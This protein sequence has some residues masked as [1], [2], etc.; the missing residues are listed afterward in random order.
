MQAW[1][2]DAIGTKWVIDVADNI[3]ERGEKNLQKEIVTTIT[4]FDTYYSRFIPDSFVCSL[5]NKKGIIEVEEDFVALLWA[6]LPLYH[7]TQGKFTPL[8]GNLLEK[9]G[10]DANY[11]L[12]EKSL[13]SV[14]ALPDVVEVL[15]PNHIDLKQPALFDFGAIGKGYLV[16]KVASVIRQKGIKNFTVDAGGDILTQSSSDKSLRVG[17]EHPEDTKKV[18]GSIKLE[19]KA[20]CGSAG[21]RR[22]WGRFHHII[23]PHSKESPDDTKAVW[24]VADN[25]AIADGLSTCLFFTDPATLRKQ[26]SFE[27]LKISKDWK[28]TYSKDL[29]IQLYS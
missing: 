23:N 29:Q 25:C 13:P 28:V 19:N 16:D 5:K 4:H 27:F 17:L 24:V 2:F 15:D 7:L 21:N 1:T 11:S 14:P 20:V 18:I 22:K 26:F 3:S 9:A 12:R 6:Y 10:Y 8:V